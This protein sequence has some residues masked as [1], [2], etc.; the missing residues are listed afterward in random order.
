M[1]PWL[2]LARLHAP[3]LIVLAPL[4]GAALVMASPSARLSW[5]IAWIAG[6]ATAVIAVDLTNRFVLSGG[7]LT[8]TQEGVALYLDGVASFALPL[9]AGAGALVLI[10]AAALSNGLGAARA[11]PFALAL[12]LCMIGG[13]SGALVAG[14]FVAFSSPLKPRG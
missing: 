5:L 10:A 3:L 1:Q 12:V 4:I 6:I 8:R 13:W 9:L 14:D 11:T 7:A 2:D